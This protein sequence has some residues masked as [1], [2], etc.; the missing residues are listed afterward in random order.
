MKFIIEQVAL[1]PLNP[2]AAKKLLADMGAAEWAEDHVCA[3]GA[4]FG[5]D[6]NNEADLSFNYDAIAGKE[7]EILNYTKG[8]NWMDVRGIGR[9]SHLGMHCTAN[10]L[11]EWRRFFAVRNIRVA[12]EVTTQS[13]TNPVIDGKRRYK[14]V[15]FDTKQTLGVDVKFIVRLN[16]DGS[17]L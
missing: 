14:Y 8:F 6:A 11:V 4:V 5:Q 12:Q 1:C 13:H 15:I 17:N 3:A 7:L 9:V 2:A 10:E 16:H